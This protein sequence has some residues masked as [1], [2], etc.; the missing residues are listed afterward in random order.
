[1]DVV[2]VS[3]LGLQLSKHGKH[4]YCIITLMYI[5]FRARA[6]DGVFSRPKPGPRLSHLNSQ[7]Y[8]NNPTPPPPPPPLAGRWRSL[9]CIWDKAVSIIQSFLGY[10]LRTFKYDTN[11]T[12]LMNFFKNLRTNYGQGTIKIVRKGENSTRQLA[13][14]RNHLVSNLRCKGECVIP[15]SLRLKCPI[16]SD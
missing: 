2:I 7:K 13:R 10:G 3:L 12:R 15:P 14:H 9:V 6:D 11:F 4:D 1:M 5:V 16:N 8:Q